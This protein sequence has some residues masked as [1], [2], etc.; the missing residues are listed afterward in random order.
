M[1][2]KTF[3]GHVF[4]YLESVRNIWITTLLI[5]FIL[6]LVPHTSWSDTHHVTTN[7]DSGAGSLRQLIVT[8]TTSGDT[9]DFDSSLSGGTIT[10][11][12]GMI[13]INKTLTIDGSALASPVTI[14]GNLSSRI[15]YMSTGYTTISLKNLKII[16][17]RNSANEYGGAIYVSS[18]VI[19]NIN[20]CTFNNNANTY[21]APNYGMGGAI[22]FD[23]CGT[24]TITGSTF[25]NNSAG[26]GGAIMAYGSS[27]TLTIK[28][29][30]FSSNNS[31]T[32]FSSWGGGALHIE[33]QNATLEHVTVSSNTAVR[34]GGIFLYTNPS[35]VYFK[36]CI[37]AKNTAST[38]GNDF[39]SSNSSNLTTS[40]DY[41][42]IYD[43]NRVNGTLTPAAHDITGTDPSLG[44]LASNGGPTQ[45]MAIT[46]GSAALDT[47]PNGTN[48][49]G[50][51]YTTD[52]RGVARPYNSSCDMGSYEYSGTTLV[53][54]LSFNAQQEQNHVLLSW[55]T[56]SEID[57]AGFHLW[58]ADSE[59]GEYSMI[60]G[61]LILSEGS[62]NQG[63]QYS[64]LDENVI[65]GKTYFYLLEDID[66]NGENTFHGPISVKLESFSIILLSPENDTLFRRTPPLTFQ[67]SDSNLN[68]F[69]LQ[70]SGSAD[71]GRGTITLPVSKKGVSSWVN[72][73]T[74]TPT[75]SEWD[76]VSQL[77]RNRKPIYWRV[78][79]I[80]GSGNTI[81]S[82]TFRLLMK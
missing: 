5:P 54:M 22:W 31:T 79:S 35:N 28:N 72:G 82:G 68:S 74:Y 14:S 47:I 9:I 52:Q 63:A 70:F 71:F 11:T 13:T 76:K 62:P 57:T 50:S 3:R 10:L 80:D 69:R 37:I 26:R 27:S 43:T 55:E 20:N 19:V 51:I 15:F 56:G 1:N 2:K 65:W 34:G 39:F 48:G 33:M 24:V 78:Y 21:S 58:R 46:T 41:N 75:S 77:G 53:E 44:A 36:N 6:L 67:W 29:S 73:N 16:N 45:T 25:S 81:V 66:L 12:T 32:T 64:Y 38:A 4:N 59:D 8:D 61:S 60:T 49:C 7:A 23:R 30:T 42:L 40:Q 17:G 18:D